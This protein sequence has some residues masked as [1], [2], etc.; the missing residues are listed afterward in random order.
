MAA[1]DLRIAPIAHVEG[2][3]ALPGSKSISNRVLLIA[4]LAE[5]TTLVEGVLES[6]DTE[7]MLEALE[8]LGVRFEHDPD[9]RRATVEGSG[10]AF[11]KRSA[12]LA[13]GNAGTAFRPLTAVLATLGGD[14]VLDGVARMR[15]RP[16]GHLVDALRL[17]GAKV[18]YIGNE[19]Y[20]PLAISG[21]GAKAGGT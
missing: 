18:R 21:G 14:Y 6:D 10:G 13:L 9:A 4:A 11:R 2:S 15:E 12:R 8:L 3:V 19:G 7:R 1:P 16:I 20:P 5:G 17:L